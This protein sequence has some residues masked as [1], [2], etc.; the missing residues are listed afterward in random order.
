MEFCYS[1][2]NRIRQ[3]EWI[4][5]GKSYMKMVNSNKKELTNTIHK[6]WT[7]LTYIMLNKKKPD[8]KRYIQFYLYKV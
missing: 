2:V 6:T 3:G 7:D 8:T 1:S 4:N 5:C